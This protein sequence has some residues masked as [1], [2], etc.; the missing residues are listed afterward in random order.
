MKIEVGDKKTMWSHPFLT[1]LL[2]EKFLLFVVEIEIQ[3]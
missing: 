1:G 3:K 2:G